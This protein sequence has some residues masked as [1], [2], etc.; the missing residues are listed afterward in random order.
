MMIDWNSD[1]VDQMLQRWLAEDLGAGDVSGS[2]TIE[3]RHMST[4]IIHMKSPGILAGMP[5]A[6]RVFSNVDPALNWRAQHQD[7][8]HVEKGDQIATISGR[9]RSILIGERLALNLLQRMTGIASQTALFVAEVAGTAVRIVDTRK[10]T[11]GHRLFEKYAVRIGGG[12]NHRFNL[13]DAV[14]IKDNHIKAAGSIRLAVE[15]ARAVIPHTMTIEVE[16]E[17]QEQALEAEAAGANIV[18]LD[19]MPTSQM[20]KVTTLLKQR[21][22]KLIVEA[23]GGITLE[24]VAEIAQTGVDIISVGALTHSIQ[25]ADISLDLDAIKE[26]H[27]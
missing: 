23:S 16:A 3:D 1:A 12:H 15:H 26:K 27:L 13:S 11:P 25:A 9:T 17:T 20:R 19:N 22:E 2:S 4:G 14:M 6:E 18:L 24:N 8:D 7:G 21:N 10:T 5:A